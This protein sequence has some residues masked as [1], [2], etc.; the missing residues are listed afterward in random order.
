VPSGVRVRIPPCA[1]DTKNFQKKLATRSKDAKPSIR[2][3]TLKEKPLAPETWERIRKEVSAKHPCGTLTEFHRGRKSE[4]WVGID[5]QNTVVRVTRKENPVPLDPQNEI[6]WGLHLQEASEGTSLRTEKPLEPKLQEYEEFYYSIWRYEK[7]REL[8]ERN[9]RENIVA[10]GQ[11]LTQLHRL[12]LP[13]KDMWYRAELPG[14]RAERNASGL[15]NTT[16]VKSLKKLIREAKKLEKELSETWKDKKV[17]HGD[18]HASN[19]L[20]VGG[21]L[22]LIDFEYMQAG[23]PHQ[24]LAGAMWFYSVILKSEASAGVLLQNYKE[25]YDKTRLKQHIWIRQTQRCARVAQRRNETGEELQKQVDKLRKV[26]ETT[27]G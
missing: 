11:L 17:V 15:E 10:H 1:Q 19:C 8:G 25:D 7:G 2:E 5:Y 13:P 20:N 22:V 16:A 27:W 14:A 23:D 9:T 24:D 12:K 6:N 3:K 4:R 18:P 26:A 21:E